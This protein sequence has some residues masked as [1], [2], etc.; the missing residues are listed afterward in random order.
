MYLGELYAGQTLDFKFTT[1]NSSRVPTTL[2]GTPAISVYKDNDVVQ[3]TSGVTLTVDFDGVTGLNHVSI[4]T[5]ASASFYS[6][7]S[8]F[9]VVITAGTVGGSSVVGFVVKEFSIDNRLAHGTGYGIVSGSPTT[10]NIPTSIMFPACS[11]ANQFVGRIII[12]DYN[13]TTAA[14]R[15]QATKIDSN[16]SGGVLT[17]AAASLT[18][19]PV[20]GD[21][22]QIL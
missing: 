21:T 1:V 2:A 22:F 10:T 13:T 16:T 12:F 18:T 15:G 14:L 9:H 8:D 5:S 6:S 11:I 19:A 17:V 7:G 20:T 4:D 3:S